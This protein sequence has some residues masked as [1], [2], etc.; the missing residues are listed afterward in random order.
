MAKQ[1]Q[2]R[3]GTTAQIASF[4]GAQGEIIVDTTLNTLVVQ[5]GSTV[6]GFPLAKTSFP[7]FTGNM[8]M[9]S[10]G[11]Y[12]QFGDGTKQYTA[13]LQYFYIILPGNLYTPVLNRS[14]YYATSNIT[15]TNVYA[16][17]GTAPSTAQIQIDILVGGSVVNS[18]LIIPQGSNVA[19]PLT[20]SQAV[21]AGQAVSVNVNSGNGSDLSIKFGYR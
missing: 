8:T 6:G 17:V 9:S 21:T 1:V 11:S 3:R 20:I 14:Q 5:D 10:A 4:T 2:L 7:T 12:L 15:I 16:N 18:S 13:A 19:T